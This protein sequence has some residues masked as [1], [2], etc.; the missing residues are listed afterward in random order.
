MN[1]FLKKIVLSGITI[2]IVLGF[3]FISTS[4]VHADRSFSL[5][6]QTGQSGKVLG[7]DGVNPLWTT[8]GSGATNPAAPTNSV[9]YNNAGAFGGSSNFTFDGS[10]VY[11]ANIT[12]QVINGT[13]YADQ[14]AGLDICSKI[15][16]ADSALP[17]QGGIISLANSNYSCST[18]INFNTL[19]KRETLVGAPGGATTITWSNTSGTAINIDNGAVAVGGGL[20]QVGYGVRDIKLQ[21]PGGTNTLIGISLGGTKGAQGVTLDGVTFKSFHQGLVGGANMWVPDFENLSFATNDQ[22]IFINTASNSGENLR[23]N[24]LTV[25]D[26]NTIANC[27]QLA[28]NASASSDFT[29]LSLDDA[30]LDIGVGNQAV[31]ILGGHG[32]NPNH[33]VYNYIKV[34][35]DSSG[36]YTNVNVW[37][38][39][40]FLD[41]TASQL[42]EFV[43]NGGNFRGYGVTTTCNTGCTTANRFIANDSTFG[44]AMIQ[45]FSNPGTAVN[46]IMNGVN[47]SA[48]TNQPFDSLS[49]KVNSFPAGW[50][51]TPNNIFQVWDGGNVSGSIDQNSHWFLGSSSNPSSTAFLSVPGGTTSVAPLQLNSG[52]LLTSP[53]DGKFEYNGSSGHLYF[54]IG[55]NRMQLDQQ[56]GTISSVSNSD[57]TL[58]V[59]PTTGAVV[60]SLALGHANTW[61]GIQAM[62][63]TVSAATSI[64]ET[65]FIVSPIINQSSTAGYTTIFSNTTETAIGSGAKNLLDLQ[66]GSSS[67]FKVDHTGFLTFSSGLTTPGALSAASLNNTSNTN[68]ASIS[69]PTTG[70]TI[71]RNIA[72]A[73]SALIVNQVNASSTGDIFDGQFGGVNKFTLSTAGNLTAVGNIL[74]SGGGIGYGSGTG[75][76]GTVTQATS[77]TTGVT[78]NTYTG[79]ITMNNAA[80][81]SATIASFTVTDSKMGA[82]DVVAIQHDSGGTLGVYTIDPSTSTAGSFVVNVRNDGTV[83]LSEAL[84][85]RFAIIKGSIN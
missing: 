6:D 51:Q 44:S 49:S 1:N 61:T 54:D 71:A 23:F 48:P 85:L 19:N 38:F 4:Y 10:T 79:T 68:N 57:G 84:V 14:Y 28:T 2:T 43:D 35:D 36:V 29:N 52:S 9:Q 66:V 31:N 83:P 73:N 47:P 56:A 46:S 3:V 81:S 78:L 50:N 82:N 25:A 26:C 41:S 69:I 24:N 70:I 60:A 65:P 12:P 5:P 40:F 75:Q 21:G 8:N 80:L 7:T 15:M 22:A 13:A 72:D 76:G 77:K 30:Q 64:V 45:G 59:S 17:A 11:A 16:A 39:N 34:E 32:E 58:T 18:L 42:N 62:T 55:T 67:K 63:P 37:G 20:Q 53:S 27:I 74:S 33:A